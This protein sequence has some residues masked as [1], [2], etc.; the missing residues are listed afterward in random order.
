MRILRWLAAG[1]LGTV[2]GLLGLVG[3]ILCATLILLPLGIPVL[4]I[5]RRLFAA[6]EECVR[7]GCDD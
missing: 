4:M 7:G 3:V 5:T 1:L 2:A 6:F